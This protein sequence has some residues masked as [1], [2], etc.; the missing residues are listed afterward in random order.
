MNPQLSLKVW[1]QVLDRNTTQPTISEI[2]EM[3]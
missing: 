3:L 1:D 2:S